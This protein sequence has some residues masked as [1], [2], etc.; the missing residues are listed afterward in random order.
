MLL[1][2]NVMSADMSVHCNL[3]RSTVRADRAGKRLLPSMSPNMAAKVVTPTKRLPTERTWADSAFP[4][5]HHRA[6]GR[7]RQERIRLL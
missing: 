6:K 2:L 3:L 1:L 7:W 4:W 5:V